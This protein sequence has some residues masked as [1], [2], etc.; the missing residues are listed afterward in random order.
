M[1]RSGFF[2]ITALPV[3][4]AIPQTYA[5]SPEDDSERTETAISNPVQ[6]IMEGI[7]EQPEIKNALWGISVRDTKTGEIILERSQKTNLVP[8]STLK[9]FV[10]A[11]AMD[12][13]GPEKR[14]RTELYYSGKIHDGVLAGNVL[15]R[16]GGDPSLGS[17][18]LKNAVPSSEVFA[19]WLKALNKKGIRKIEGAVIAD[20]TLFDAYQPGSWAWEDIGNYYAAAPSALTIRD[21]LYRIYFDASDKLGGPAMLLRTEP[22]V[23][24]LM[25]ESNVTTAEKGTGDNVYVYS[26]PDTDKAIARGTI[27]LGAK[28]F[29]VKGAL[30]EPALTA[31][32]E[33]TEY[34][35]KNGVPV[36]ADP[37]NGVYEKAYKKIAEY[38]GVPLKDIAHI[39]NKRSFNLYAELLL[40]QLSA[41][42]G[43]NPATGGGGIV[44]I[45][46]FLRKNGVDTSELKM[47]DA[48]GL[49]RINLI[50][51]DAF[52]SMLAA[53]S[54]KKYFDDYTETM[55][56][57]GDPEAFGHIKRFGKKIPADSLRIKSGSLNGV[58]SYAGYLKTKSGR[59]FA[60]A[61]IMNNYAGSASKMD[62]YQEQMITAI[63]ENY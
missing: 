49:S 33:F 24:G 39:T 20:S 48:C 17:E 58:R 40:R 56:Y 26:F 5:A 53:V 22:L 45:K 21:N 25:L 28:D 60:F 42:R 12:I 2:I 9:L 54:K 52:T 27:P 35:R 19:K 15:I 55:V 31:A 36:S 61:F 37:V 63:Y 6:E 50:N 43:D 8:A 7:S 46:D 11:A 51:A 4:L 38:E 10:T 1:T 34:L 41:A 47:A 23:N 59:L 44:A 29:V 18:M 14:F 57:P 30:P 3:F 13:L 16:G 32:A 62:S